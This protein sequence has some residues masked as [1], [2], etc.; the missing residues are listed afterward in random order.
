MSQEVFEM[1]VGIT[2]TDETSYQ[3]YRDEMG[4]FLEA[5]GGSFHVDVRVTDVLRAP[6]PVGFNRLFALRFPNRDA[7]D[8]LFS[9]ERYVAVRAEHFQGSVGEVVRLSEGMVAVDE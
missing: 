2:V 6:K 4:P 1:W 9:D 5:Y 7:R 3:R 8:G